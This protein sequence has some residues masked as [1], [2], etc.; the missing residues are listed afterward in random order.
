[1]NATPKTT[2]PATP[3][4]RRPTCMATSVDVGP[5]MTLLAPRR[6]RNSV[7]LSQPRRSTNSRR[8]MAMWEA[9]P[10]K[11]V[12]LSHAKRRASATRSRRRSCRFGIGLLN[13]AHRRRATE[14]SL[15]AEH[16]AGP[17]LRRPPAGPDRENVGGGDGDRD[18]CGHCQQLEGR[19]IAERHL[20]GDRLPTRSPDR[21]AERDAE[22]DPCGRDCRPLREED[23]ANAPTA[24]AEGTQHRELPAPAAD[25]CREDVAER[26]DGEEREEAGEQRRKP[27]YVP[28]V[29]ELD[30]HL[31]ALAARDRGVDPLAE[32]P[33]RSPD[34]D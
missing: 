14:R 23:Q 2:S 13:C 3:A 7:S 10:P 18:D 8:I 5:G 11:A 4:R 9:G 30:R 29:A 6:S 31:A 33:G 24:D 26:G 20:V 16:L 28:Q 22:E 17:Q 27:P 1:M 21:E 19:H 25:R 15:G 12:T 32:A 34:V